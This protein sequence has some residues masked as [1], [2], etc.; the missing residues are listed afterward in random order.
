MLVGFAVKKLIP[1]GASDPRITPRVGIFHVDAGNAESLYNWFNGPSGGIESHGHIRLSGVLEQYRDTDYE[2][3][4]NY[5]ANPFALSWESQ[6]W[7]NGE[8]TEDQIDT[9]QRLIRWQH[10]N[11]RIPLQVPKR[12]DGEGFG[13]HTMFPEWSNVSGKTCPGPLRKEQFH[14]IIVPWMKDGAPKDDAPL[15]PN[16]TKALKAD[17][18][19]ERIKALR[20][21]VRHADD[22]AS[23]AA[24][25]WL[26]GIRA[27]E[28]AREE[29]RD[30]RSVLREFQVK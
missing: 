30:S 17:N 18:R 6:G 19:E 9:I 13:Y 2:A 14:D 23:A 10:R 1:P 11:H 5:R 15:T 27:I 4:A 29:V 16:I 8:W 21:V 12:W 7:G 3:D 26:Q 20:K 24:K 25:S 28:N 22:E